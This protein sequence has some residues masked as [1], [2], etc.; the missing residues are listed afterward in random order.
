[1]PSLVLAEKLLLVAY[2]MEVE[3]LVDQ[4]LQNSSDHLT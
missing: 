4:L 3:V 1:M 2:S